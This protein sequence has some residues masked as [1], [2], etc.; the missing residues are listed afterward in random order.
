MTDQRYKHMLTPD[1]HLRQ[2][3]TQLTPAQEFGFKLLP[4]QQNRHIYAATDA[5]IYATAPLR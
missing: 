3:N 5:Q 2:M 4:Y 1:G